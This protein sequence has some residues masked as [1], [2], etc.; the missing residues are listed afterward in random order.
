MMAL[1]NLIMIVEQGVILFMRRLPSLVRVRMFAVVTI[2]E[3]V[4]F[5]EFAIEH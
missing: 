4:V 1:T 2:F 5:P 3:A